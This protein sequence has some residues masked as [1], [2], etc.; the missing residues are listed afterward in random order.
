MGSMA[1]FEPN[2]LIKI[3]S[4]RKGVFKRFE[5]D[6]FPTVFILPKDIKSIEN[7]FEEHMDD[8][9]F[10]K[11]EGGDILRRPWDQLTVTLSK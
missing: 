5:V 2:V 6:K 1:E 11:T 10:R 7:D 9:I 4:E 8:Y 3:L